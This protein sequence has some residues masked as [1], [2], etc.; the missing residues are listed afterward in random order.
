MAPKNKPDAPTSTTEGGASFGDLMNRFNAEA[1]PMR[2]MLAPE[3]V[4]Y[5]ESFTV[6]YDGQ[7][8]P[9]GIDEYR[10]CTITEKLHFLILLH[11]LDSERA[12]RERAAREAWRHHDPFGPEEP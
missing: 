4:E 2:V 9:E 5:L 10:E 11:K 8:E 7:P 3:L 6:G 12:D 1:V